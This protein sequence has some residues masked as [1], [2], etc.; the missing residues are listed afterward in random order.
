MSQKKYEI[1][2]IT[3]P[4]YP[5]LHRIRARCQV[6]EQV[7]PGALG[8]YVQTED[9][10]SQDGTCWIYDQAICCEEAV[11]E[12]DGR[13]F[14]GAV[15]RGSALIS[16]DAR[17]FEWAV[18]EGN[19]SFFSGE[20]KEDARLSGNAV[21]NRSDNGLSPLIG[22]KSNVYGSVCGWFVV[23]DNI[24]EGEHYLNRTEDMFILENGKR[25]VL[26]KQRKLEPPEEYRNEKSKREDR[27]R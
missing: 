2:E 19:S 13:M 10:L 14:D 26:V 17:M 21:V 23:N 24:F 25:E 9:N 7:G 4:K 18:A 22:R 1:T 11:V 5:W 27:E 8:G 16:G 3:H 15:A 6:N 12:D 20:L